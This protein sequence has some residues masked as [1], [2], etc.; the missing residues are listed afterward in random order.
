LQLIA[1]DLEALT[2]ETLAE[3]TEAVFTL[4]VEQVLMVARRIEEHKP[5]LARTLVVRVNNLDFKTLQGLLKSYH[6]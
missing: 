4:D 1:R 3:L 2:D 5:E 6:G